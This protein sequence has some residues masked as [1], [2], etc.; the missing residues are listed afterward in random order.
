MMNSGCTQRVLRCS[1]HPLARTSAAPL[2]T[3]ADDEKANG[4]E[5][6]YD[7]MMMMKIRTSLPLLGLRSSLIFP[8]ANPRKCIL[9]KCNTFRVVVGANGVTE[10]YVSDRRHWFG[11]GC[12]AGQRSTSTYRPGYG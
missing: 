6:R 4:D 3:E 8:I 12:P 2:A 11:S 1:H 10:R 9:R 5:E 7:E